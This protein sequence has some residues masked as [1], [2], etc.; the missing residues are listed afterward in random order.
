MMTTAA[1]TNASASASA[2]AN[3]DLTSDNVTLPLPLP[4]TPL[5]PP[6]YLSPFL[7]ESVDMLRQVLLSC[8]A[9]S[10]KI[11]QS[12]IILLMRWQDRMAH[13][14]L[15]RAYDGL[16]APETEEEAS[17]LSEEDRDPHSIHFKLPSECSSSCRGVLKQM[18]SVRR[19][20]AE[21]YADVDEFEARPE[22]AK[23]WVEDFERG[24][25][26]EMRA[27]QQQ[28]GMQRQSDRA[29]SP[30]THPS[31]PE[32]VPSLSVPPLPSISCHPR[33]LWILM[34]LVDAVICQ[35]LNLALDWASTMNPSQPQPPSSSS[36]SSLGGKSDI[37]SNT[38]S[39]GTCTD[40]DEA[41]RA[42]EDMVHVVITPQ[43]LVN[44]LS[45]NRENCRAPLHTLLL[46]LL[47]VAFE[48]SN[49]PTKLTHPF[50][51]VTPNVQHDISAGMEP[52]EDDI[53]IFATPITQDRA[54]QFVLNEASRR[55]HELNQSSWYMDEAKV[56]QYAIQFAHGRR[57]EDDIT[58]QLRESGIRPLRFYGRPPSNLMS[59]TG[60][61]ISFAFTDSSMAPP[62]APSQPVQC[63]QPLLFNGLSVRA[64][65][66]HGAGADEG[67]YD[68]RHEEEEE[69]DEDATDHEVTA[70]D[71]SN[72][73][74]VDGSHSSHAEPSTTS[75]PRPDL[76]SCLSNN[77]WQVLVWASRFTMH[78]PSL[79]TAN[80]PPHARRQFATVLLDEVATINQL[81]PLPSVLI[82][83]IVG[84]LDMD[85]PFISNE[86]YHNG[87]FSLDA[88]A[89]GA[90]HP[91]E[92]AQ[93]WKAMPN[94]TMYDAPEDDDDD[95]DDDDDMDHDPMSDVL[96]G[97]ENENEDENEDEDGG[98][99][100]GEDEDEDE[101]ECIDAR[102]D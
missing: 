22:P 42:S 7:E 56:K 26:I 27:R 38:S 74:S 101:A 68:E 41:A 43:D 81:P 36:S 80:H 85:L 65:E 57:T 83:I 14:L 15:Q 25:R 87:G 62:R 50:H 88:H 63:Y 2:S 60:H 67:Q 91:I 49:Y 11:T 76:T 37:A 6:R 82:D 33:Q 24:V 9:D 84:Y 34:D 102:Q 66:D 72:V 48:L 89:S 64:L 31:E 44:V 75:S 70:G 30:S 86:A 17:K 19:Q 93:R 32:P 55:Q 98:E 97:D 53:A 4:L 54:I 28:Q 52:G 99:G 92:S 94:E 47:P 77:Q 12:A 78:G 18:A 46:E 96:D 59:D 3:A 1:S 45:I 71:P 8:P 79:Y 35:L 40:L 95:A 20:L 51:A 13:Y 73:E 29:S 16:N 21:S 58:V 39:G 5:P 100:E 61:I 90:I 23:R 10:T 69:E